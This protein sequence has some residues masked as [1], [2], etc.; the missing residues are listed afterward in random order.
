MDRTLV[1]TCH[2]TDE[3]LRPREKSQVARPFLGLVSPG[4]ALCRLSDCTMHLEFFAEWDA[5]CF[6]AF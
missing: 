4:P 5:V 2:I 1:G 6:S 3:P